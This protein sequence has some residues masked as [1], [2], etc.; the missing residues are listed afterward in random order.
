MPM[1]KK[2]AAIILNKI[3]TIYNMK[4]DSDEQ[5]LKEWLHLLIKYGDYQPTLLKTEQYI[6]EKKYKP[7]LSDILAYKTKTKV[8]DTIPKEQTKAYKL[9]HDPE[10]KKRHEERK[11]KWAQMKQEWGVVD[12]EY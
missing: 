12:E 3:N 1:T 8:I 6:R 10:Y 5:V 7:T 9:Q 2:E 4:F 11:K